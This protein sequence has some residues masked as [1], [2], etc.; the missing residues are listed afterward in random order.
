MQLQIYPVG[1]HRVAH[2]DEVRRVLGA[3][4]ARNLRDG[5]NVTL[6]HAAGLYKLKGFAVNEYPAGG[7][8]ST[9]GDGLFPDVYHLCPALIVEMSEIRHVQPPI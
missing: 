7:N 2:R 9:D 5:E 4:D 8:G 1:Q 3:H 6:F